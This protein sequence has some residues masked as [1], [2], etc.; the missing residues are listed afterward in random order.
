MIFV[1]F[2]CYAIE[3]CAIQSALELTKEQHSEQRAKQKELN[4]LRQS[5]QGRQMQFRSDKEGARVPLAF[6]IDVRGQSFK[7]ECSDRFDPL[8]EPSST[9]EGNGNRE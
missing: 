4:D 2:A 9:R 3:L 1:I 8:S 6:S 7:F 5:E